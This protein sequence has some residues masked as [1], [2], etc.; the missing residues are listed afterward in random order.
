MMKKLILVISILFVGACAE[1]METP[2]IGMI[3][4]K[5]VDVNLVME[6]EGAFDFQGHRLFINGEDLGLLRPE[7]ETGSSWSTAV[8]EYYALPTK[9]GVFDLTQTTQNSLG[10]PR[11]TLRLTLDGQP[12]S[13]ISREV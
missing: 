10:G 1:R 11:F 5:S 7:L 2:G 13:T 4:G 6:L 3:N 9:Y 12:V 8:T